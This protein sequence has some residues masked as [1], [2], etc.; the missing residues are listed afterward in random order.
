MGC[1]LD[2]GVAKGADVSDRA[3]HLSPSGVAM[4][5]QCPKAW[6]Y[7]YIHDAPRAEPT[8]AMV[9]GTFVHRVLELVMQEHPSHRTEKVAKELASM[10]WV[11]MADAI[12]AVCADD[13]PCPDGDDAEDAIAISRLNEQTFRWMAWWSIVKFFEL[14]DPQ[15]INV[16]A[17]EYELDLEVEGVPFVG[18]IDLVEDRTLGLVV[19]DYK[20][21]AK[22]EG[23]YAAEKEREK[24][25]Q[26]LLYGA[27][28]REMG[29][30]VQ[31]VGLLFLSP[32]GNS[33]ELALRV[34]DATLQTAADGLKVT[35]EATRQ[36]IATGEARANTGP[37]CGW[38]DHITSCDEGQRE[39]RVR[40]RMGR[41]IGPA[42]ERLGFL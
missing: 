33:G 23:S 15:K 29:H 20:T 24:L 13:S 32:E 9:R 22:P 26:V 34:D 19:D 8:E 39:V 5:R 7:V 11:E 17:T 14:A 40:D 18:H 6:A 35:W 12:A 37:L 42:R 2:A 1:A 27:A 10:V 28:L 31:K 25:I 30:R 3:D 38:C 41:N 4:F 21:S 36:V 16:W